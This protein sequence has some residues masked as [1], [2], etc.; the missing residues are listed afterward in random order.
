MIWEKLILAARAICAIDNPEDIYIVG[1]LAHVQRTV[2][3][4]ASY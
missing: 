4:F 3:K 2:I 1:S